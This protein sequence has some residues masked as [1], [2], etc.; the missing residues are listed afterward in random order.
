KP[1]RPRGLLILVA[2]DNDINVLLARALL[3]KLGHRPV[4]VA[5]GAD[6]FDSWSAAHAAAT[7]YDLILMDVHMPDTDG[8]E[9]TRRIRATESENG[10]PRT[11]IIALT[12]SAFDESREACFAAGMD[13]F[14]TKPLD[15]ER[16]A[17][18]VAL[19]SNSLA[20]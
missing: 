18:A 14:L 10:L 5:N 19:D 15:R 11:R 12:A 2:E 7:P 17:E 9:A 16:L 8:I 6:A 1:N 4:I 20:A 3:A 13:S